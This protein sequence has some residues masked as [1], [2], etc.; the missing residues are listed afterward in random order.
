M[1]KAPT[2]APASPRA[3]RSKAETQ[4]EFSQI[5]EEIESARES[6]DAKAEAVARMRE[7]EVRQA[8]EGVTVDAVV[9]QVSAL[10]L[11]IS[12]TLSGV[13]GKLTEE[14]NRLAAV[15]AAV[16]IERNELERLHKIDVAATAL[17]QMVQHYAREKEQLEADMAV[18]RSV[19]QE[20]VRDTERER[21]EQEEL[22]K[23]QR[24][25]EIDDYEYKKALERKRAQDKYEEELR[26][27]EKKNQEKQEALEKSW[28]QRQAA[29]KEQEEEVARLRK[30]A[31]EF[32]ATL[33]KETDRAAKQAAQAA[34]QE[35]EQKILL[36]QKE[37]EADR[38]VADLRI[39]TAEE[40]NTRLVSQVA[41]LQ[42]QAEEAKRQVQEIA[43]R[44]IEGAS[45]AK[46]LAHVNEIAIEQAKHRGQQS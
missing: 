41:D 4:Q 9:Q 24:Q 38:R 17:D 45:G 16:E 33:Q 27:Q 5:Q 42:K 1:A 15:R 2:K 29:L 40:A 3:R 8:A 37:A 12:R 14:V 28:Q 11:D 25:R 23:K 43:L 35:S 6:A 19:W 22:L 30:E 44:A 10:G 7:A 26:L 18:Q 20:N 34:R 21:K 46:A 36:M 31:A 32:P 39:K 13:S